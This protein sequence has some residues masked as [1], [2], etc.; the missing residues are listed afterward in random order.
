MK[1]ELTSLQIPQIVFISSLT[2]AEEK[3]S[4]GPTGVL[5]H[6]NDIYY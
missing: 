3:I 5:F 1:R 2:K 4:K 6:T